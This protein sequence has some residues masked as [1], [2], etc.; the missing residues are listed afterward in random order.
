MKGWEIG[1]LQA[2]L[3]KAGVPNAPMHTVDQVVAH[4]QTE[5]LGMLVKS[6]A[7]DIPL[8]GIAVSFDGVRPRAKASAPALGEHNAAVMK[9]GK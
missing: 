8:A 2:A 3:D 7:T 1:D 4:P 6:T 9:Q 5:V